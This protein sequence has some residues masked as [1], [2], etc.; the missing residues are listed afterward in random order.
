[1]PNLITP[2]NTEDHILGSLNF[3]INLV[4][5][6][7]YQCSI[8]KMTLPIIKQLNK[9]LNG[10]LCF[11]FR[12]FPLKN[13]HPYALEA[14]KAAEAASFQ[15]KFWEMHEL[16]YSKQIQL[17]SNIWLEL[18]KEL[19]LNLEKFK[20][21]FQSVVIENK[22]QDEFSKGLRS[23]VN[24]TPCFYINGER[25]DGDVSYEALKNKLKK[26]L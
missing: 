18:A 16:L 25:C 23:G 7:D 4:E 13:S 15:N 21:D 14:A 22:I 19:Q 26:H 5:Y 8:C 1:M 10:K 20:V 6:G 3:P 17:N 24:G 2:I 12:H 11:A 9:E